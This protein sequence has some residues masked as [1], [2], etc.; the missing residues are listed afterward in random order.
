MKALAL[1]ILLTATT[2]AAQTRAAT[3]AAKVIPAGQV[4]L[5]G[6]NVTKIQSSASYQQLA[7]LLT[8]D[9]ENKAKID[10]M[11]AVCGI[12]ALNAIDSIAF[13]MGDPKV[14]PPTGAMFIALKSGID[15]TAVAVCLA[16]LSKAKGQAYA[17]TKG[18]DGIIEIT[19][20]GKKMYASFLT[21]D[22]VALAF[23]PDDRVMLTTMISG[24]GAADPALKAL[25]SKAN[26]G[27]AFWIVYNKT[28]KIGPTTNM[29]GM[30]AWADL[31]SSLVSVEAHMIAATP[32]DAAATTAF[33]QQALDML[34][35]NMA[36]M[37]PLPDL[38]KSVVIKTV[39]SESVMT[40]SL[41]EKAL[42]SVI[43]LAMQGGSKSPSPERTP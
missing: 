1:A 40:L 9:P 32:K 13:A 12:D 2:A 42:M 23:K 35:Q 43:G 3:E 28:E 8:T 15:E 26:V 16:K 17:A 11:K 30:Y 33:L 5:G 19:K 24:K 37:P 10:E 29:T 22:V 38:M 14:K 39:G 21:K 20:D 18:K 25:T 27:A 34:K 7:P 4:I 41:P 6:L 31:A 36:Q